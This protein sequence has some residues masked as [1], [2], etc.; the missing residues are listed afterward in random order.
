MKYLLAVAVAVML[1][2]SVYAQVS[3][4]N[5]ATTQ[6]VTIPSWVSSSA[7]AG[8]AT[9]FPNALNVFAANGDSAGLAAFA[10]TNQ[11]IGSGFA[12]AFFTVN[13]KSGTGSPS[14]ALYAEGV[15]PSSRNDDE[16]ITQE[17]DIDE[18]NNVNDANTPYAGP[19]SG[20]NATVAFWAASGG[21]HSGV[22]DTTAA[23]GLTANGAKFHT[24]LLFKAG[25]L[26]GDDSG[27][28]E[29][30]AFAQ[31]HY[32]HWYEPTTGT[33]VAGIGS[34]ANAS[35]SPALHE[36]GV[37]GVSATTIKSNNLRGFCN[38]SGGT[39]CHVTFLVP[40]PDTDYLV[41]LGPTDN[42]TFWFSN[43]TTTGFTINASAA[44]SNECDWIM[45]R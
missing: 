2:G 43:R 15:L 4:Q 27:P 30:V 14:W 35:G 19:P 18:F 37:A 11:N 42:K 45:I 44:S 24:G 21:S 40:E 31:H 34:D 9:S 28:A 17:N 38:F 25:S 29:A 13:D 32:L 3:Q 23:Y 5:V 41:A 39:T 33:V 12:G 36:Y 22:Y 1:A 7:I 6:S 26:S 10:H 20:G 16:V 8:Y